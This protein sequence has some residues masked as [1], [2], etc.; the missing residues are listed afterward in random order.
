MDNYKIKVKDEAESKEAQEL[1]FGLGVSRPDGTK[2]TYLSPTV[3]GLLVVDGLLS[4]VFA[5]SVF[6]DSKA[7]ELTLPQL[8]DLVVLKRN[9]SRDANV[10]QGGEIPC[11]YDLY[12][13]AD[14]ELY[15]YH[16]G[17]GKWLLSNL[18]HDE[19]Y[20]AT[21]KP[22]EKSEHQDP[23]LISGADALRAL[24]DGK[25]V[26]GFSEENEEW[27]PIVYF[28]VQEVVNGLY[29]FRLKPQT[30]KLELE[31]PKPF[32]PKDG[33]EY[34]YISTL[35]N[36]LYSH[37]VW[38]DEPADITQAAFGAYRTEDDVKKAV[39][40]LRKIRGANS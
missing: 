1:F 10:N 19:D 4:C 17:K 33:D 11:L 27:I 3:F 21:L 40:Q 37:D 32:E 13:T 15:F 29:K 9:D 23:A 31:L 8:R 34:F 16:C 14:K 38:S 18:N 12:L 6:Y 7:K 25:E 30:I 26:E 39:E 24:A 2:N 36:C 5:E 22:I 28:S 35:Q 20:Y